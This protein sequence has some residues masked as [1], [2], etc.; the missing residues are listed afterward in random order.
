MGTLDP[1]D[2]K[3]ETWSLKSGG[4]SLRITHIPTGLFV[5][6]RDFGR[7]QMKRLAE[8]LLELQQMVEA[9]QADGR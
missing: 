1:K 3:V 2:L 9:Q 4:S 5:E 7:Q 6:D 8:K